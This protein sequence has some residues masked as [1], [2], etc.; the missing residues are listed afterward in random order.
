MVDTAYPLKHIRL[1]QLYDAGFNIADFVYFPPGQLDLKLVRKLFEKHGRISLRHFHS[2]EYKHFAC[3]FFPEQDNWDTIQKLA[4]E[5]NQEYHCLYNETIDPKDAIFTG[6]IVLEDD[7]T[8]FVEYFK[9]PGTPRD[10]EH[11]T[12]AD[13]LIRFRREIGIPMDSDTPEALKRFAACFRNFLPLTRPL[14]IEF[15]IYSYPI[16]L[17]QTHDIV[18]EWRKWN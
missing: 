11:K 12:D 10:I 18:W 8:Y 9:G 16:G 7:R 13:G 1:K 3:P 6:C 17:R 15:Q 2:E 14:L 4:T 5:H